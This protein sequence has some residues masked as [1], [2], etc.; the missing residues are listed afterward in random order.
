MNPRG[1]R[2]SGLRLG[3]IARSAMVIALVLPWLLLVAVAYVSFTFPIKQDRYGH[4]FFHHL[5]DRA[6]AY[7]YL[8]K[9]P[10][11]F[12]NANLSVERIRQTIRQAA[13]RV[14]VDPCLVHAVALYE[15]GYYAN[16]ITTTGAMGL[17]ALMPATAR[18][19]GVTDPYQPEDNVDAGARLLRELLVMFQGDVD[20]ALAAYNAGA[21]R[22]KRGGTAIP[23]LRETGDYVAHVK[24]IYEV[25][26][27]HVDMAW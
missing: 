14:G 7:F 5:R 8:L 4:S 21:D 24:Q 20:L 26:R 6:L 19:L 9:S 22:V 16:T 27:R 10:R 11:K 3:K 1:S 18:S 2:S 17:L 23:P 25:C 15:S 12:E 13:T